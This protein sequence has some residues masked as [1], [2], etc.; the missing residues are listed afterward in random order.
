MFK[1]ELYVLSIQMDTPD[2]YF[3]YTNT[4]VHYSVVKWLPI[5]EDLCCLVVFV[6]VFPSFCQEQRFNTSWLIHH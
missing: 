2:M 1:P 3:H 5:V 6:S 4:T